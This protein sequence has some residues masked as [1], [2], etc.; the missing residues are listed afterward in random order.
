[1]PVQ[2]L[3]ADITGS[4]PVRAGATAG[5]PH[6]IHATGEALPNDEV[7]SASMVAYV[8]EKYGIEDIRIVDG[9]LAGWKS[10]GLRYG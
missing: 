10:A 1:L 7:L 2:Y 6:I 3:P 5:K 9:G 8:L 4:L